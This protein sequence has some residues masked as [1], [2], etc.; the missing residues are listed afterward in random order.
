VSQGFEVSLPEELTASVTG[1][2]HDYSDL[3]DISAT[4][5]AGVDKCSASDRVDGEAYGLEF[6]L[7]RPMSTRIGGLL[8]YTLSHTTRTLDGNTFTSDF[9]RTHIVNLALS[10]NLGRGWHVGARFAGYSGRPYSLVKFDDPDKPLEA[11]LIGHRNALR[12]KPFFRLD[13]RIE[14]RWVIADRGWVSFIV[15]GFNVTAQK[16]VVDF[17]CRVAEVVGS[18]TGLNCGGQE[19]GPI[20]IPSIGVSGGI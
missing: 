19:I 4:C 18:Q 6:Q 10:V 3:T 12:R 14:K 5:S 7:A 2:W 20:S 8:S 9:D 16:E 11:K 17:D 1:F 15:E 13:A